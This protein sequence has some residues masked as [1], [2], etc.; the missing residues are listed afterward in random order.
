MIES[1]EL[2]ELL[3]ILLYLDTLNT[4]LL[5]QRKHSKH[6]YETC[7]MFPCVFL[8]NGCLHAC[9]LH[10]V[11]AGLTK[12]IIS[13]MSDGYNIKPS[14]HPGSNKLVNNNKTVKIRRKVYGKTLGHRIIDN[15]TLVNQRDSIRQTPFSKGQL[16]Q[17]CLFSTFFYTSS[18]VLKICFFT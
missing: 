1:V 12:V 13:S 11:S 15:E 5:L 4:F 10:V 7:L 17:N 18:R 6:M 8:K 2:R 9:I 3:R 14:K 16:W